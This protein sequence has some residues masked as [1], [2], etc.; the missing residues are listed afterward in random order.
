M[1]KRKFVRLSRANRILIF[2]I[3]AIRKNAQE[4]ISLERAFQMSQGLMRRLKMD[5]SAMFDIERHYIQLNYL[6]TPICI[7]FNTHF[8]EVE[9]QFKRRIALR[10]DKNEDGVPMG[11][12]GQDIYDR[13]LELQGLDDVG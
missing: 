4:D 8:E 10:Q 11:G 12:E 2:D 5:L 6:S 7:C 9:K 13:E 1:A 3:D